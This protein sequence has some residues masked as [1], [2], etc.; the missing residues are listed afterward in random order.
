MTV[1][2]WDGRTLAADKLCTF[3]PTKGTVTKIFRHGDCLVGIAGNLSVGMETL[4]WF[5]AGAVPA[6]YPAANRVDRSEGGGASLF[7]IRPDGT[8]WKYESTPVP[9]KFDSAFCAVGSGDE[10]ALVAMH[11]GKSAREAVE[12]VCRFN[13]GCGNGVDILTLAGTC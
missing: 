10:S 11:C 1:I 9:W 2:A 7:V 5:K 8:A 13:T 4:E 6:D 12:I 3:G